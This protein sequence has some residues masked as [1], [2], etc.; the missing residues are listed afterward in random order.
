MFW[1]L[2]GSFVVTVH[3]YS[4]YV[5]KLFVPSGPTVIIL[6]NYQQ[7]L[8]FL[9]NHSMLATQHTLH[10]IGASLHSYS[11]SFWGIKSDHLAS[12]NLQALLR[13]NWSSPC[14]CQEAV[15]PSLSGKT[16]EWS[17]VVLPT[18]GFGM[19]LHFSK[20]FF[21]RRCSLLYACIHRFYFSSSFKVCFG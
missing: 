7:M 16:D 12:S 11:V 1:N 20:S 14:C 9:V 19:S 18:Y 10:K 5:Q 8:F 15:F 17:T 4:T 6:M 21:L 2:S 13:A 3:L